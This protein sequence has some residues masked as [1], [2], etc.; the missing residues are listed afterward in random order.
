MLTAIYSENETSV[1]ANILYYS[2]KF[3]KGYTERG[4]CTKTEETIR[5]KKF[6]P[7]FSIRCTNSE[8]CRGWVGWGQG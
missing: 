7:S 5:K 6:L 1:E 2:L 4:K 8:A 3:H